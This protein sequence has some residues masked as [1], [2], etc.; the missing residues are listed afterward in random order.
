[1]RGRDVSSFITPHLPPLGQQQ[2]S[3]STPPPSN[4]NHSGRSWL[5]PGN[6]RAG[7]RP[8]GPK[9]KFSIKESL[10]S[11]AELFHQLPCPA[12]DDLIAQCQVLLAIKNGFANYRVEIV[13]AV[14]VY[15]S[16]ALHLGVNIARN[17]EIDENQR[18]T[19]AS[20]HHDLQLRPVPRRFRQAGR[21]D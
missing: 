4:L 16:N 2:A 3:V 13:D 20:A 1:M 6:K 17:G 11:R 14:E 7:G 18:T 15:V 19:S 10:L 21:S 5:T 12:F 8:A 9:L